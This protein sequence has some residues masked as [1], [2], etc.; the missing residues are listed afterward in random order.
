PGPGF[1]AY[2]TETQAVRA[3][4]NTC[5][6][7]VSGAQVSVSF[8]SGEA[9]LVLYDDGAHG[10]GAANDGVYANNWTPAIVGPVTLTVDAAHPALG[11]D[12]KSASGVVRQRFSYRYEAVPFVWNDIADGTRYALTGDSSVTIPIGFSFKFFDA[13]FSNVTI[14]SNGFLAF[15]AA[16]ATAF[17]NAPIPS[18]G[19]PNGIVA[20]FWDDLNPGVGG[21]VYSKLEGVAPNRRLTVSW[22]G[23]PHFTAGGAVSFQ[24]ILREGSDD[25]LFQ[26][27]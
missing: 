26:Y 21:S 25:I 10:D 11:V 14:S 13:A 19:S 20:P 27:Q 2:L 7:P 22:V 4:V 17:G 23:V 5:G 8:S 16:G 18:T 12:T 24:A 6:A 1:T 3:S 15:N 9:A